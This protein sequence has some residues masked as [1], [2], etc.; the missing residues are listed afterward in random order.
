MKKNILIELI[1]WYGLIAILGAYFLNSFSALE[2]GDLLYQL[3]NITGA[4]GI[5]VV[6][7]A[8]K[9]Y[10]PMALNIIW[11]LIGLVALLKL[12]AF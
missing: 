8:K 10:Q 12:L 4:I 2:A 6:S 7:Y 3:L 9:A 5:I 11:A 1:G